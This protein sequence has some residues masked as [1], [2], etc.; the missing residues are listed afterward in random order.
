M[1]W[2]RAFTDTDLFIKIPKKDQMVIFATSAIMHFFAIS[3]LTCHIESVHSGIRPFQCT[4]CPKKFSNNG[5]LTRHV[6]VHH[7]DTRTTL[8]CD[9]CDQTFI[10]VSG[11]GGQMKHIH[12]NIRLFQCKICSKRFSTNVGLKKHNRSQQKVLKWSQLYI[13]NWIYLIWFDSICYTAFTCLY[14]C[15]LDCKII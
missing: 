2:R 12:Y 10:T 8:V 11:L 15:F 6:T 7:N 3:G 9:I 5:Y 14:L 4:F 13:I 1:R